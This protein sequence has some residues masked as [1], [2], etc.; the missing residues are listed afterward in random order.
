MITSHLQEKLQATGE[1]G[2]S[3]VMPFE[4][5]ALDALLNNLVRIEKSK[6]S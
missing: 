2:L 5:Q 4:F 1:R 6:V 3:D